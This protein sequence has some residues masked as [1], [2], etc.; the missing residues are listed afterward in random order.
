MPKIP[1]Q[2]SSEYKTDSLSNAGIAVFRVGP[3]LPSYEVMQLTR[4]E[5]E[6]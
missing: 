3:G 2:F 1:C 6:G 4:S 5:R